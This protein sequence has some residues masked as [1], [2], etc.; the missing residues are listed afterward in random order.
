MS[1]EE[2][3]KLEEAEARRFMAMALASLALAG[4]FTLKLGWLAQVEAACWFA[5]AY[6]AFEEGESL[7]RS[8][9]PYMN[10]RVLALAYLAFCLWSLLPIGS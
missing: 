2:L 10:R 6:F 5:A 1:E 8:G 7:R 4:R 9:R 3:Q